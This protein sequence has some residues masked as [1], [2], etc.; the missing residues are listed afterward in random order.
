MK[1][2]LEINKTVD[3]N[4]QTYF[5]KAKKARKKM[6]GA[7]EALVKSQKKLDEAKLKGEDELALLDE[8][9]RLEKERDVRQQKKEWFET[10][11]WF[12]SSEGFLVI[13]GRDAT[14]NE[15]IIKKRVEKNDIIFHTDMSGSPFFVVKK[16]INE[17][18]NLKSDSTSDSES[19]AIEIGEIT[20]QEAAD[21]TLCYSKAWKLGFG[22]TEVFWVKPEQVTK[23]AQSGEYLAKGA[24]MIRGDTNYVRPKISLAVG[25][26]KDGRVMGGPLDA[27]KLHC[28][29]YVEIIQGDDKPSSVAKLIRKELVDCDLDEIIRAIPGGGCKVKKR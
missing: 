6:K 20:I 2:R 4:A 28:K 17:L 11:R 1:I 7:Q 12:R 8:D 5:E 18:H 24:F 14:T 23:E 25:L 22:T 15:I 16:E 21:A 29:K 19:D 9:A 26:D 3:Q 10:F 13:G 27:I